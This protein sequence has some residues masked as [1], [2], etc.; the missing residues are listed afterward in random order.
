MGVKRK[1]LSLRS[2]LR[3]HP[4]LCSTAAL[5]LGPVAWSPETMAS[6]PKRVQG[7]SRCSSM[8][9]KVMM[10]SMNHDGLWMWDRGS[11]SANLLEVS[12][13]SPFYG[14]LGASAGVP[15]LS[16]ALSAISFDLQ[17]A[18]LGVKHKDHKGPENQP[19]TKPGRLPLLREIWWN[20]YYMLYV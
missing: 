5:R 1:C 4:R 14:L 16:L 3:P 19:Q 18:Q 8:S 10:I 7:P 15:D 17:L 13:V 9:T 2:T 12:W 6:Q 20:M 11:A